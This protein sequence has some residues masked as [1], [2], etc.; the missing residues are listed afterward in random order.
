MDINSIENKEEKLVLAKKIAQKVKD[1]QTIGF[2][3]GSTSYLA[4]IEIG[5]LTM[6]Y[7]YKITAIP[8]SNEIEEVCKKYNINVGNLL[9]NDI[10]WCFDGAD[11][12]DENNNLLKGA[13]N[14]LFREKINILNSH[15][16]TYILADKT[17]FVKKLGEKHMLPIEIFPSAT[18]YVYDQLDKIGIKD[19]VYKGITDNNNVMIN[20]K[21]NDNVILNN[22]LAEKI[23][24]ITGVI[25]SGLFMNLNVK[26]V[27]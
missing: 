23:K 20:V 11:E 22:E 27:K 17:K 14:A 18:K 5:K 8:T 19:A 3:S 13:G 10:D 26:I 2:G 24:L 16:T 4:A 25:E 1:G 15:S 21:F 9:E 12:V 6:E 7:G